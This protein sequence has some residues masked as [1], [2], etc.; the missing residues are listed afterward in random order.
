MTASIDSSDFST[1][2]GLPLRDLKAP[3]PLL[4]ML[5]ARAPWEFLALW[6]ALPWLRQLPVGDGHPVVVFP[7]LAA[8][9]L[10][11][12]PLRH[13]LR[14]RGYSAHA[15]AQGF[16]L[17]ARAGVLEACCERVRS[18]AEQHGE[19]VSLVGWSLG[20][21]YAREVAKL[22]PQQVRSVITLGSPFAGHPRATNAWRLYEMLNGES[23]L[24]DADALAALR[25]APP[26][27]TTSIYSRSDGVVAWQCS[28]NEAAPL[29]ENIEVHASH[30]GLGM[31][32]LVVYAV[33]DRLAQ[34]PAGW[35]RFEAPGALRWFFRTPGA[36]EGQR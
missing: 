22:H 32:P 26:V 18:L 17:G 6:A 2:A 30:L 25:E 5:E 15:W 1:R 20:G 27:P 10:T 21:L 36:E 24:E 9:D 14:E 31:N 7:G 28:V 13:V 11:T 34:Q 3:N 29:S 33:L 12:Q 8:N 19:P 16:N 4:L 35:Q 23:V